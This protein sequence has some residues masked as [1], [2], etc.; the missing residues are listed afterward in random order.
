MENKWI[1]LI[2]I[3]IF[4]TFIF[5]FWMLTSGYSKKEYGIKMWKHWPAR[6]SYWQAAILYSTGFTSIT[7][8]LLKSTHV[9]TF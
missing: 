6:L 5:L 4:L 1:F 8:F 9:L 7:M 2:A 3:L